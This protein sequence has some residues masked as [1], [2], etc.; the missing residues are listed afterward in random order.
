[1]R[2][3]ILPTLLATFV[4]M[5]A[6]TSP[7]QD[8]S[9][10]FTWWNDVPERIRRGNELYREGRFEDAE[11]YYRDA[12][13]DAPREAAAAFNL[14]LSHARQER[15]DQAIAAFERSLALSGKNTR[16]QDQANYNMGLAHMFQAEQHAEGQKWDEAIEAAID[17]LDSFNASLA[18]NPDNEDALANKKLVQNFLQ[19]FSMPPPPPPEQQ[20]EGE[21][22]EGEEGEE[23]E[24]GDNSNNEGDQQSQSPPSEGESQPPAEEPPDEQDE[25]DSDEQESNQDEEQSEQEREAPAEAQ[26]LT[27]EQARRLLNMIGDPENIQLRKGSRNQPEPEKPW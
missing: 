14:G 3:M 13:L 6:T 1:M 23:G 2:R 8:D 25:S 11:Q 17:A 21:G 26:N 16:I 27:P 22:Q 10:G 5:G 15:H 19:N 4:M 9:L 18:V 20:G 24:P 12:Q 7:A